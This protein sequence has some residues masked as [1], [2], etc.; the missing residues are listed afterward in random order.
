M[1]PGHRH[2]RLADQ[3]RGE[4]AEMIEGE[5]KDPRIGFVT[6]T[7]VDL[8]PDFSHARVQVS[9]LGDEQARKDSLSGLQSATGYVRRQVT[10]RLRLRRAPE[11]AFAIDRGAEEAAR[12][13]ELLG[14]IR[15]GG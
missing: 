1:V 14:K 5:L 10:Q 13:E 15:E 4:V 6:V 2:D 12:I 9:I 7:R 11:I 8:S 3:I